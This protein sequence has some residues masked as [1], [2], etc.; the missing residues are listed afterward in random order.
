MPTSPSIVR[1]QGGFAMQI[2]VC[3]VTFLIL[4]TRQHTFHC[5]PISE[6]HSFFPVVWLCVSDF[7]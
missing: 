3:I 7:K 5:N 6:Q 1:F 2:A 4:G